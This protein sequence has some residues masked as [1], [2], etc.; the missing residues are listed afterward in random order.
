MPASTLKRVR[1]TRLTSTTH[2][3]SCFICFEDAWSVTCILIRACFKD[4]TPS[5]TSCTCTHAQIVAFSGLSTTV[6]LIRLLIFWRESWR[7]W[8]GLRSKPVDSI[9]RR[10]V[11]QNGYFLESWT[12][13]HHI[14]PRPQ[15]IHH[16]LICLLVAHCRPRHC[17]LL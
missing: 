16:R 1:S 9:V 3:S 5:C 4:R 17:G 6:L 12:H 10:A 11:L 7:T 14:W 2:G 15:L 8:V 13:C